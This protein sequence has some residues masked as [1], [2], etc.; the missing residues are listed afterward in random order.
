VRVLSVRFYPLGRLADCPDLH[1]V[2]RPLAFDIMLIDNKT[3]RL[4]YGVGA[5]LKAHTR[6]SRAHDPVS[7]ELVVVGGIAKMA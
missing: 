6:M 5:E 3:C 4:D 1:D 7:D 2:H